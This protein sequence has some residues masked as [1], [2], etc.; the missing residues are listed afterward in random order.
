MLLVGGYLCR[1]WYRGQPLIC[2]IC[3][4]EGHRAAVCPGRDKCRRCGDAG[5]IARQCPNHWGTGGGDV[6]I[7]GAGDV[8]AQ[9][10]VVEI[11]EEAEVGVSPE[12]GDGGHPTPP[13]AGAVQSQEPGA[14]PESP[15]RDSPLWGEIMDTLSLS[16]VSTVSDVSDAG[17][18]PESAPLAAALLPFSSM[19]PG[20]PSSIEVSPAYAPA[21]Q[22]PDFH[23]V[24]IWRKKHQRERQFTW[25]NFDKTIAPRLDKY[26]MS[27]NISE[28]TIACN[29]FPRVFRP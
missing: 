25:F 12:V 27:K 6:Q 8:P 24:D 29:I 2:H 21:G 18:L 9:T 13:R 28:K 15:P 3:K 22:S 1:L 4:E 20:H 14:A 16:P 10:E 23:L 5:H 11:V 19:S 26:F 17:S 7:P